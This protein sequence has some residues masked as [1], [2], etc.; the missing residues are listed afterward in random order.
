MKIASLLLLFAAFSA[1]AEPDAKL[2]V[3]KADEGRV[4]PGSISF[5]SKVEDFEN[6]GSVRETKYLV[7]T[8]GR[9]KSLVET[10]FPE[11]QSGR[12][13][14]MTDESMWFYT[15]D[16]RRAARVSPQQK[17]T[18][19]VSNGDLARTNFYGDYEAK[20]VGKEKINGKT[21]YK[22]LL[23]ANHR[24]VTYSRIDYWVGSD[25]HLPVK[26]IFYAVSGKPLKLADYGG[27]KSVLGRTCITRTTFTDAVDKSRKSV[28]TF[29]QHKRKKFSGETFAKESLGG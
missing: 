15:P 16:I 25:D 14:L 4:P 1:F 28:L 21:V 24:D 18:G 19:E 13:L 2:L 9:E 10:V 20:I 11:R 12:K 7:M 23:S 26:A 27:V 6:G 8:Q 22:L 5:V 29:S 17:L 3:K